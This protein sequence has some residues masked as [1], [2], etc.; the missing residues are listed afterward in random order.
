[1]KPLFSN[2]KFNLNYFQIE[3]YE[4]GI[5]LK[6]NEVKSIVANEA[7]ID[8]AFGIIKNDEVFIINMYVHP[9]VNANTFQ[10]I[11]PV[12]RRKLLLHR[13]QIKKIQGKIKRDRLILVPTKVYLDKNHIKVEIA[14]AKHKKAPDKREDI[15]KRDLSREKN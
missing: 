9:Y 1:M 7:N 12:R 14:L 2:K 6:G 15:K 13:T 10:T 5:E 8:E 4:A 11:D 3:T